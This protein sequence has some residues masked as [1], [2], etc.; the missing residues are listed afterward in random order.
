MTQGTGAGLAERTVPPDSAARRSASRTRRR[1]IGLGIGVVVL[2]AAVALSIA[3]GSRTIGLGTV[4]RVL[5]HEDGSAESVIVHQLRLPRTLLGIGVGAALGLAGTVMQA[6]TRN[7]LAEPGLLGVNLGAATA[8]VLAIAFLGVTSATGYVWFAFA[9][10]A[11]T[12]AAVFAL[13]G[14]G[15]APTPERQVLAGV[16]LTS[17]LGAIVWAV[18]VTRR[19]AF[20]RYRH[21]DVGS[22]SDRETATI[23]Q[24]MP[25][26][27]AGIVLALVLG[28][29]LNALS[30]GDDSATSLGA[31]PGRIRA[32]GILTVTLLCGAATAASG[33]IWFLGLAVPYAARMIVGSDHRWIL[34]YALVL[35]PALLLGSDVLG[36][37]LVAP[38]EL[39]VGVVTAFLGAPLFI[40]LCRRRRLSVL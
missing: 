9:G 11:I 32:L 16:S 7:P 26:L 14:S 19:E 29:Q 25:F 1:W 20:D 39:P 28:R 15:K 30:M 8:V 33:P 18:L 38:A 6:L 36:R 10:A 35:G 3:I 12:S 37:V 27:L 22:L 17:V 21:W 34:T 23:L 5:W 24:V 2:V 4:W 13:G 40:A 31:H